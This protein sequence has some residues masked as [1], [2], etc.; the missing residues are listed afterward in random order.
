MDDSDE[1]KSW[2][3]VDEKEARDQIPAEL[4]SKTPGDR[5]GQSAHQ[6][7]QSV[8]CMLSWMPTPDL[9]LTHVESQPIDDLP[10]RHR[11]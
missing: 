6:T 8:P 11:F 2:S 7:S 5:Q 10:L 1:E 4:S 3:F 9:C